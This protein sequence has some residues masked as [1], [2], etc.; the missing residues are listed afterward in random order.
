M[1]TMHNHCSHEDYAPVETNGNQKFI[2]VNVKCSDRIKQRNM[3][4]NHPEN[5]VFNEGDR[6]GT[7]LRWHLI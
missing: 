4:K 6:R 2:S 1:V 3:T 7:S 5:V